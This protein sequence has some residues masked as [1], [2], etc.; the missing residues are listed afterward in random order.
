MVII[1]KKRLLI[2]LSAILISTGVFSISSVKEG[3]T[4]QTVSLPVSQKVIVIDARASEFQMK[5]LKV[6]MEQQK[7]KQI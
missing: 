2:V 7:Q 4:V 3:D 1:S 6:V 5:E